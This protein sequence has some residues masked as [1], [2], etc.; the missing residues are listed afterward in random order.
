MVVGAASG[1]LAKREAG[2][3]QQTRIAELGRLLGQ[4]GEGVGLG[5]LGR[6]AEAAVGLVV[7]VLAG[8]DNGGDQPR[9]E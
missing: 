5:K 3:L 2:H 1:H 7:G 6:P 9:V 4:E 8:G